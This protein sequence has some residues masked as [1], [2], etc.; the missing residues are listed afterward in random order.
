M[1]MLFTQRDRSYFQVLISLLLLIVVTGCVQE[2]TLEVPVGQNEKLAVN[3]V[4]Y[5][6][7]Q[8]IGEIKHLIMASG[9]RAAIISIDS[10]RDEFRTGVYRDSEDNRI[11]LRSGKAG[12]Q[13]PPL[14]SGTRIPRESGLLPELRVFANDKTLIL[15]VVAIVALFVVIYAFKFFFKF[16]LI[17]FA[18]VLSGM[19]TWVSYPFALPFVESLYARNSAEGIALS[20]ETVNKTV[21]DVNEDVTDLEDAASGVM[22]ILVNRP[23][24][25]WVTFSALLF[26][27]F[28]ILTMLL[29]KATRAIKNN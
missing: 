28:V 2:L 9:D 14:I 29:G 22:R 21:V 17:I 3:D 11:N 12:S 27:Y 26:S 20:T 1:S 23:D 16:S 15:A 25:T 6:N 8:P 5:L 10:R 4:V 18:F 19:L 13:S 24:P 7:G